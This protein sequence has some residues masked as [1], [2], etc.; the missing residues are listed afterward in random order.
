M[1]ARVGAMQELESEIANFSKDR[2]KRIK[3]AKDKITAAKR[4]VEAAKKA[5]KAKEQAL[6]TAQVGSK[7][8]G[9]E[10]TSEG[11]CDGGTQRASGW[12]QPPR[13]LAGVN[14]LGCVT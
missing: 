14:R 6:Q 1:G 13:H 11:S 5:L 4:R 2:D 10:E 12:R 7:R 9:A 3:A 8:V